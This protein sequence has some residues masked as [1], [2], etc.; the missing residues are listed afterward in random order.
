MII[1]GE[2]VHNDQRCHRLHCHLF[3]YKTPTPIHGTPTNT[4][5]KHLKTELCANTSSVESDLGGGDHRYLGLVLTD[6]KYALIYLN[7]LITPHYPAALIIDPGTDHIDAI[8]IQEACQEARRKYYECQNVEKALQHHI[9][10]ATEEEYLEYLKTKVA[11]LIQEDIPTALHYLF[12]TYGKVPSEEVKHQEH[13]IRTM[14][15]H[16]ADHM[17]ILYNLIKNF[18]NWEKQLEYHTLKASSWMWDFLLSTTSA[19]LSVLLVIRNY[20]QQ[21]IKRGSNSKLTSKLLKSSSKQ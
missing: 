12:E 8:N 11:Q 2:Q 15:F 4:T 13:E 20:F 14:N 16:P 9:Q 5:L 19:T 1:L 10:D 6:A 7:P 21:I 18:R 3:K 17:I